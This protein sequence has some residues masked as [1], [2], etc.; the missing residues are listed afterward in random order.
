MGQA[1]SD[2]LTQVDALDAEVAALRE[3]TQAIVAELQA[4]LAHTIDQARHGI[5]RARGIFDL[6]AQLR[7]HP[8]VA[9]GVAVVFSTGITVS[10]LLAVRREAR[11]R[12]FAARFRRLLA[13]PERAFRTRPPLLPRLLA[14]LAVAAVAALLRPR[15]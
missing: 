14:S 9:I 3:R 8:A 13:P 11:A 2:E 6:P 10:I 5:A 7:A 4:R 1:P 15:P 12:T